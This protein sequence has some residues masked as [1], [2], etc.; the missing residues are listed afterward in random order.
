M[1]WTII[2]IAYYL[3]TLVIALF[4]DL[5]DNIYIMLFQGFIECAST[6]YFWFLCPIMIAYD[7]RATQIVT[8]AA[9]MIT[10]N[11]VVSSISDYIVTEII[12]IFILEFTNDSQDIIKRLP[13]IIAL[14]VCLVILKPVASKEIRE[15]NRANERQ[16]H[17]ESVFKTEKQM[18][19]ESQIQG[20]LFL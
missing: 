8:P 6:F 15:V 18:K 14:L 7:H 9:T 13:P 5:S 16:Q 19:M 4:I 3:T 12:C 10:A 17:Q 20:A 1:T 2:T 11:I